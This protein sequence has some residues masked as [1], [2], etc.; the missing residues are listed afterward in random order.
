MSQIRKKSLKASAWIYCGFLIGAVNT[1]LF[2]REDGFT[3]DQYG[4][5]RLMIEMGMLFF[6]F[7]CLGITNY[8]YK[9]FPYYED[10]TETNKNDILGFALMVAL[11]GFALTVFGVWVFKPLIIQKFSENSPLIVDYFYFTLPMAFFILLYN[12][13]EAYSYG[14]KKGV[15]TS[16]LKE[17]VLRGYVFII[18]IARL[19]QFISFDTFV[20]LFSLQY[21][22]IVAILALHLHSQKKLWLSFKPSRVTKK[23]K[24]KI[25]AIMAFTIIVVIVGVLRQSI[26]S[27]VLA[28]KKDLGKVGVF[29]FAA[30]MVSLLQAPFRS[31]VAVTIPILSRAWK[32]KKLDEISRIYKRSSINLLSFSLL[33]FFC[34][35]LN[36]TQAINFFGISSDYLEG[37]WV[38]FMLG[39]VTII[40]MGTGVNAQIIGTSN[41]WRFELWASLLLTLMIIPL[42]YFLTV[43]YGILGPAIAN[44]VSFTIYNVVRIAFLWKKYKMQPFSIKTVEI[45]VIAL[46][47]YFVVYLS[48][49]SMAG[50]P[51]LILRTALYMGLFLACLYWR[52]I[53]PDLMPVV[54]TVMKK[55]KLKNE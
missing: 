48:L 43:K 4:L 29:G 45:I 54:N 50:L 46:A 14:F 26:D 36:Y 40:E 5:T 21:A 12:V 52:N 19:F 6:A 10:N 18:V 32:E 42:S 1:W 17:T 38:F 39:I 35:W 15:L 37:R 41:F 34:V 23:F 24:K 3:V 33:V 28:A 11:I 7:S 27:L 13:L 47:G 53:S 2:T 44:I 9:F 49:G 51:G 30:Y 55:L 20:L 31:I 16:L 8:L 22:A 25:L